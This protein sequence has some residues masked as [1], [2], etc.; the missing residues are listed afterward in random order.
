VAVLPRDPV[1]APEFAT[2]EILLVTEY[3]ALWYEGEL[4]TLDGKSEKINTIITRLSRKRAK[5]SKEQSW[6]KQN[7]NDDYPTREEL[8]KARDVYLS[9]N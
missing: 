1:E 2:A 4:Q 5:R 6:F 9:Q 3:E 7:Q 8:E